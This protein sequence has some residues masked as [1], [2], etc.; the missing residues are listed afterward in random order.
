MWTPKLQH[1]PQYR[2]VSPLVTTCLI[3]GRCSAS[4]WAFRTQTTLWESHTG[5]I[6]VQLERKRR[7]RRTHCKHQWG[8]LEAFRGVFVV[9][10][11]MKRCLRMCCE[12]VEG[13]VTY[14]RQ[15][16][17]KVLHFSLTGCLQ[18]F[19]VFNTGAV[20]QSCSLF[21][22]RCEPWL[23]RGGGAMAWGL[24]MTPENPLLLWFS[25]LSSRQ[26]L[27]YTLQCRMGDNLISHRYRVG[28]SIMLI[29]QLYPNPSDPPSPGGQLLS[30]FQ[31][32]W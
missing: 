22:C 32:A 24:C 1:F 4:N 7:L 28:G 25:A 8:V 3:N 9:C 29:H 16:Q 21:Q 27:P 20:Y 14:P 2:R 30:V 19:Q 18:Y 11:T 31:A 10:R 12:R 15:I 26:L 17:G 5:Q 6:K 23:T 13:N